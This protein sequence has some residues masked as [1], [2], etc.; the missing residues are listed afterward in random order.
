M[1]R[2]SKSPA[3]KT[4]LTVPKLAAAERNLHVKDHAIIS[5]KDIFLQFILQV[6][7]APKGRFFS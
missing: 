3:E 1:V 6:M 4:S 5:L 7:L 2:V